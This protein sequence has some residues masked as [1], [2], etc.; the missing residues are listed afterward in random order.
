ME[1]G[2]MEAGRIRMGSRKNSN[3]SF[4]KKWKLKALDE[5]GVGGSCLG[6]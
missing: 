2:G 1:R 4:D 5:K 3:G 6:W